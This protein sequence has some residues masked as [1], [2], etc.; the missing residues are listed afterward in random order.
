MV[1]VSRPGLFPAL[2]ILSSRRPLCGRES[3]EKSLQCQA[4][5]Q[6]DVERSAQLPH[7][8]QQPEQRAYI[9]ERI[10]GWQVGGSPHFCQKG[11]VAL[12]AADM[13]CE[14]ILKAPQAQRQLRARP[15]LCRGY[16]VRAAP[17]QALERITRLGRDLRHLEGLG[18]RGEE[19]RVGKECRSRW[20]PY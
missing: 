12:A 18:A 3:P 2:K 11:P 6:R 7:F 13:F 19:R 1:R 9:Q 5:V 15:A 4:P 8:V 16:R 20:S 10:A 14:P 17:R